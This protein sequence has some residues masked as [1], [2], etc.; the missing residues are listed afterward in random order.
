MLRGRA[1]PQGAPQHPGV[2]RRPARHRDLRGSRRA[3]RAPDRRQDARRGAGCV[4][5]RRGRSDRLPRPPARARRRATQH[6]G[7]RPQG[8]RTLRPDGPERTEEALRARHRRTHARRRHRGRRHLSRPLRPGHHDAGD[9]AEH[10]PEAHHPR[11]REPDARDHARGCARRT[12]RRDHRDRAL[13]LSEPGQQRALLPVHLPGRARLRSDR[14]QHGDEAR[15][16]A[17][18]CRPGDRRILRC[19]GRGLWRPV[20]EIRPRLHHPEALRSAPDRDRADRRDR[21]GNGERSRGPADRRPRG[22]SGRARGP[23]IPHR[24]LDEGGVRP[25]Q[26]GPAKGGL[27]RRRERACAARRPAGHR[28]GHRAADPDR[29]AVPH[30]GADRTALAPASAGDGRR[31]RRSGALREI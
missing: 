14:N 20:A 1:P 9:G 17:R 13:R 3:Q 25:G 31:G 5:G 10:G 12:A 15:L 2:P 11:A 26:A 23:R 4:L 21:G 24:L 16:R 30:R 19:R 18:D 6:L 8:R 28:R 27:R 22:L 7:M 29:A